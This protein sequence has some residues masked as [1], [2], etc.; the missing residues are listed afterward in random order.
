MLGTA[1]ANHKGALR[2][3][4]Q[5][6]YHIDID[7]FGE[8]GA[9]RAAELTQYL[10]PESALMRAYNPQLEWSTT[11][12]L[13]WLIEYD[14]RVLTWSMGGGKRANK[15]KPLD[16]PQAKK[17]AARPVTK[18]EMARVADALGIPEERR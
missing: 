15:P 16:T 3:D 10:P 5:R 2:A 18:A 7:T 11:D 6:F 8:R 12:Y 14:L 13:L 17:K 4:F 9:I 1:L